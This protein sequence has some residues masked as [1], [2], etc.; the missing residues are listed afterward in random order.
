MEGKK[1]VLTRVHPFGLLCQTHSR[2]H[3]L[4]SIRAMKIL[5]AADRPPPFIIAFLCSTQILL[6][7]LVTMC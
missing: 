1:E 6:Y 5:A 2:I 4:L 3:C 7:R